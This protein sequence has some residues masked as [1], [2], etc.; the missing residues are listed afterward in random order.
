[1]DRHLQDEPHKTLPDAGPDSTLALSGRVVPP[2]A[3]PQILRRGLA[4]LLAREAGRPVLL[5]RAGPGYGKT[6]TLTQ[7]WRQRKG[8]KAWLTLDPLDAEVENLLPA[9]GQALA[10]A[11]LAAAIHLPPSWDEAA[12]AKA[13]SSL[14]A[15]LAAPGEPVTL[16]LDEVQCLAKGGTGALLLE[17]LLRQLP[18]ACHVVMA[19]RRAPP[20]PWER[21]LVQG[22]SA[23]I[24]Y[25]WTRVKSPACTRACMASPSAGPGRRPLLQPPAAGRQP[26][27]CCS[28]ICSHAPRRPCWSA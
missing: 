2:A 16:F 18:A 7:L 10:A 9:L 28:T 11:G 20:L 12:L 3:T 6:Q 15:A 26:S 17:R 22:S 23:E 14:L 25:G 1:M 24:S 4:H 5:V 13:A 21:W 8:R 27:C 19:G